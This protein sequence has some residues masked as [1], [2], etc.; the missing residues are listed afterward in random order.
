[1]PRPDVLDSRTYKVKVPGINESMYVTIS[2]CEGRPTE[3]FVNSKHMESY[4]WISYLTRSASKRLQN[5]EPIERI[6][7]EMKET[8]DTNGGYII[9]KSKGQRA[10]SVVAHIGHLLEWHVEYLLDPS[11]APSSEVT[12]R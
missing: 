7:Q 12:I 11:K 3:L 5:G 4:P 2:N 6:I 9:P 10:N 8:C 1:M